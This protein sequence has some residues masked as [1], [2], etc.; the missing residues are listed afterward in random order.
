ME[1]DTQF[2]SYGVYKLKSFEDADIVFVCIPAVGNTVAK[3]VQYKKNSTDGYKRTPIVYF[4]NCY[5][6]DDIKSLFLNRR[7][8]MLNNLTNYL[9]DKDLKACS[10]YVALL[11]ANK[12]DS[13]NYDSLISYLEKF[14]DNESIIDF[15]TKYGEI[16]DIALDRNNINSN[17]FGFYFPLDG[18][19]EK[20]ED[21]LLNIF[22]RTVVEKG[23][24]YPS[25]ISEYL[26][27]KYP[28]IFLDKDTPQDLQ[29]AFYNRTL[30]WELIKS[31]PNYIDYLKDV[32]LELLFKYM[33][34][35]FEDSSEELIQSADYVCDKSLIFSIKNN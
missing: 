14:M 35:K 10:P 4:L 34:V 18:D 29:E 30:S 25:N 19:L 22:K 16:I 28:G 6:S 7:K 11:V 9:K 3:L 31:N 8:T 21:V 20:I 1:E 13:Y 27:E 23:K 32:D 2:I 5:K 33:L 26:K 17:Q 12:N 24:A 15:I